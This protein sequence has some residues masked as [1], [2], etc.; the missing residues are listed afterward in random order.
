MVPLDSGMPA[1]P[2]PPI[3]CDLVVLCSVMSDS[4][5]TPWIVA[6]QVPCPWVF[7]ARILVSVAVSSS[8]GSS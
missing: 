3:S 5:A 2:T 8:R 7:Q 4:F 6:R 1:S